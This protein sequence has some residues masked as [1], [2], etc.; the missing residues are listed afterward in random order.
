MRGKVFVLG[1]L[2]FAPTLSPLQAQVC[3]N[4][5]VGLPPV[6]DLGTGLYRTREGGLYPLG[7][8]TRPTAHNDAGLSI[9]Q[10]TFPLDT[11][12]NVDNA[13]GK[14]VFMSIGMSN[15]KEEFGAFQTLVDS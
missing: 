2:L 4:S 12:G 10:A 14:V 6:N 11:N 5:S 7:Q 15:A 9:A 3:S 1:I 8:N 13:A